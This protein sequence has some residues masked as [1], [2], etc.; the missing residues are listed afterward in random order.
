MNEIHCLV[1][2]HMI[3]LVKFRFQIK[4]NV[5]LQSIYMEKIFLPAMTRVTKHREDDFFTSLN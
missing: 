3:L 2:N 1:Q 5:L 4:Q